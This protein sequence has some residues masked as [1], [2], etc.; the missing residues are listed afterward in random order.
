MWIM[1]LYSTA[2]IAVKTITVAMSVASECQQTVSD[3]TGRVT[4]KN[5][6]NIILDGPTKKVANEKT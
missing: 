5:F 2:L 3:V 4:K 1:S 6:V